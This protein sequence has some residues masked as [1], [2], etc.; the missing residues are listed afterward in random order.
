MSPYAR[1]NA[2][3]LADNTEGSRA[4]TMAMRSANEQDKVQMEQA[5]K[6]IDTMDG[7]SKRYAG[8]RQVIE[9]VTQALTQLFGTQEGAQVALQVTGDHAQQTNDKNPGD[10][11]D[12]HQR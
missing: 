11:H 4:Y 9:S 1:Q 10:R 5:R 12:V 2:Q 3:A 8:G 7:F 6:L